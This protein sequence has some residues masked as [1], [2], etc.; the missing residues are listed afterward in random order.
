MEFHKVANIFPLMEEQE[1]EE[2]VEDIRTN[3]LMEPITTFEGKIIDGRNRYRA[4]IKAEVKPRFI[5]FDGCVPLIDFI[6]SLNLQRRHLAA[7]QRA[8]IALDALPF[9]EAEAKK[10]QATSTGGANPQLTEQIPGADSG[11]ARQQVARKFKV[12]PHYVSD[13]K[14]IRE[15]APDKFEQIRTSD[16]TIT[17][18]KREI[19]EQKREARRE[20]NRKIVAEAPDPVSAVQAAKFST[21]VIDPP[22]DWSDE[23]DVDQLG[24]A[25]TDYA[26][27]PYEQI[28]NLPV[29]DL[30]DADCHLYLWITN[31]SLPK[32]FALLEAWGFRYITALTWPKP[33]FGMGNY[34]RG[35]TEHILFGVRG[36]QALKRKNA[37]TL[38]P[39]WKRGPAGHSSK[40]NEIYEFIES[41][42]PGPFL[43]MFSR[44]N[45]TGWTHWG[46]NSE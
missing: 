36:S 42:S 20:E 46:E 35:Q 16:K 29:A 18:A 8:A 39:P 45:R 27:M 32:G 25:R 14:Q 13:A 11:E 43:E 10:R 6:V 3:G 40:P 15:Q 41:C 44:S 31:R 37:S 24:R 19:K 2:F 33:S 38:L 21:I 9:Y 4:C 30:S 26:T 1:F 5:E 34:F 7:S 23:G 17:Q 12:N 22:W 28:K